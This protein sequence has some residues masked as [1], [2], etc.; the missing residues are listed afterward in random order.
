MIHVAR[1]YKEARSAGN[2]DEKAEVSLF[3]CTTK[4]SSSTRVDDDYEL[5]LVD[6]K[7]P[8]KKTFNKVDR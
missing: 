3:A 6:K 1:V 2:R 5:S 7:P 8:R 4:F